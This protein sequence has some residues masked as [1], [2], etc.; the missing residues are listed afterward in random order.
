MTQREIDKA[1]GLRFKYYKGKPL[2]RDKRFPRKIKKQHKIDHAKF[3]KI[4]YK[5]LTQIRLSP[6]L[7]QVIFYLP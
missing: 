1:N 5:P 6:S 3:L 7:R 2:G 4:A